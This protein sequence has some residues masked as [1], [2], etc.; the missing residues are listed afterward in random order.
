MQLEIN[1]VECKTD[2]TPRKLNSNYKTRY[3]KICF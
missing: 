3:Y 1:H 2:I